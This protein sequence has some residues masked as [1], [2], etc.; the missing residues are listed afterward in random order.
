MWIF[1]YVV[2]YENDYMKIM[3]VDINFIKWIFFIF[4][5]LRE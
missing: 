1:L 5:I 4:N 2:N 3:S